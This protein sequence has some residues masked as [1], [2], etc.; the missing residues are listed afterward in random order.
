MENLA[1]STDNIKQQQEEN[2]NII[3][4]LIYKLILHKSH[5]WKHSI[6]SNLLNSISPVLGNDLSCF[7]NC[8]FGFAQSAAKGF[9]IKLGLAL[10]LTLVKRKSLLKAAVGVLSKDTLSF[11]V[12]CGLM[13]ALYKLTLCGLRAVGKTDDKTNSVIAGVVCS[14][15]ALADTSSERRQTIILYV[16][17]RALET[18]VNYSNNNDVI[19]ITKHI[20]IMMYTIS[21]KLLQ[22]IL[23]I[24]KI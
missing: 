21:L 4:K 11:S 17:A 1:E 14:L 24:N 16:L 18:S 9:V 5:K 3:L 13:V 7:F 20:Y 2:S 15:S 12:Y 8:V 22:N 10:L 19:K 6:K 23:N